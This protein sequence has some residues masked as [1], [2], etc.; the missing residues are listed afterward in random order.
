MNALPELDPAAGLLVVGEWAVGSPERQ[1]AAAN[2]AAEAWRR[3]GR[4]EGLLGYGCLLELDGRGL[5]HCSQWT[6]QEAGRR[7]A[8]TGRPEWLRLVDGAVD[9]IEHRRATGYTPYRSHR[10][11]SAEARCAVL[12]TIEFAGPDVARARGWVDAMFDL[13]EQD[14]PP[15]GLVDAHF[16]VAVDGSRVLNLA[17]WT[18]ADAHRAAVAPAHRS[19]ALRAADAWPGRV[20]ASFRRYAAA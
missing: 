20:G 15:P 4:P 19:E 8:A 7:F 14:A 9:G 11:P 1:R 16:A 6:G 2:A 18:T 13:P 3:V 10:G 12:V 5:V 17:R